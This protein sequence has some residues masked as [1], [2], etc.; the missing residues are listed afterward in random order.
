MNQRLARQWPLGILFAILLL[1]AGVRLYCLGGPSLW[2]DERDSIMTAEG[3]F[4]D[5]EHLPTNRVIQPPDLYSPGNA[6]P[7]SNVWQTF[8]FHPPL[9][10]ILLRIWL[11]FVPETDSGVRGLSVLASLIAMILLYDLGRMLVDA[12]AALW[13]CALFALSEPEIIYAQEARAYALWTALGLAAAAAAARLAVRGGNWRRAIALAACALAM[14]LTQ[15]LAVATIIALAIWCL[16]Y[17]RGAALRQA[18][19]AGAVAAVLAIGLV[20]AGTLPGHALHTADVI[21]WAHTTG[22]FQHDWG[23]IRFAAL[24]PTLFLGSPPAGTGALA[25]VPGLVFVLCW[26]LC[27]GPRGANRNGAMLFCAIWLWAGVLPVVFSDI[28]SSTSAIL[29]VRFT[30]IAA[31]AFFLLISALPVGANWRWLVPLAAVIGCAAAVPYEYDPLAKGDWRNLAGDVRK[32][33]GPDDLI[34]F[35][36]SPD[37]YLANPRQLYDAV[38]CYVHQIPCE[39]AIIDR[40]ADAGLMARFHAARHVWVVSSAAR[41]DLQ[42][43]LPGWHLDSAAPK[44]ILAAQVWKAE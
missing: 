35:A 15:A 21:G 6:G 44:R 25:M 4:S 11:D 33:A 27:I 17:L 29:Y 22:G 7:W 37:A 32:L 19:I 14:T 10:P 23:T 16:A 3:H 20:L 13:A 30:L 42:T 31:P 36:N 1:A 8:Y 28:F 34:V 26:I 43:F 24:L 40:P 39:V 38:N 2:K 18:V 9:Y 41:P 5:W 12:P